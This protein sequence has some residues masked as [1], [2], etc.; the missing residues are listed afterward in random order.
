MKPMLLIGVKLLS[1]DWVEGEYLRSQ[2]RDPAEVRHGA[3]KTPLVWVIRPPAG[4]E[5]VV[6]PDWWETSGGTMRTSGLD[7]AKV[8]S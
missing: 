1:G 5:L 8:A 3:A 6:C 4:G 7:R 2:A